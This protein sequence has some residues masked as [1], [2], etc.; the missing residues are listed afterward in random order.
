[1]ENMNTK[2]EVMNDEFRQLAEH[3]RALIAATKD[4]AGEKV[5]EARQRLETAL[6]RAKVIA[7]EV[8]GNAIQGAKAADDSVRAHPYQ[9]IAI[10][11]GVGAVVGYLLACG[12]SRRKG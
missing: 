1:M 8:R 4:V 5:G 2:T 6:E 7:T 3:A 9:A 10:G 11:L 12:C